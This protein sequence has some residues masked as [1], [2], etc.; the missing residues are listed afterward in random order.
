MITGI[1]I[2]IPR[3]IN[4]P[5][6]ITPYMIAPNT[7]EMIESIRKIISSTLDQ[8]LPL[9]RPH[10]MANPI[11]AKTKI[12]IP[13]TAQ[14]IG[15][16]WRTSGEAISI[17]SGGTPSI[18]NRPAAANIPIAAITSRIDH[19]ISKAA[20]IVTPIGLRQTLLYGETPE[21]VISKIVQS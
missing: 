21:L 12:I 11:A 17:S 5:V 1:T 14:V 4:V 16:L 20:R 18:A 10:A 15:R 2:E 6:S 19:I 7:D 9:R 13:I 3:D 8:F